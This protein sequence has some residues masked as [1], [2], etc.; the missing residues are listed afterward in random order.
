MRS[1]SGRLGDVSLLFLLVCLVVFAVALKVSFD[2][3][4]ASAYLLPRFVA[5]AGL[6]VTAIELVVVYRTPRDAT[7]EETNERKGLPILHSIGFTVVYFS[8]VPLLGFLLATALA[9]VAFGY[10]TR[11][12]RKKLVAILAVVVPVVLHLTFVE[13]LKAPLP[14]G[15]LAAFSF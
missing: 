1:N 9:I 3:T 4:E 8:L 7:R 6:L 2:M 12:P 14:A 15:I 11:F 5:L 13:L 10:V